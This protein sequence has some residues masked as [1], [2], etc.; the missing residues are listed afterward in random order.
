M[1]HTPHPKRFQRKRTKGW[2]M[3]PGGVCCTRPGSRGN[4]FTVAQLRDL[5]YRMSDED[6]RQYCV[7]CFRQW[8]VRPRWDQHWMG[9]E[10][11]AARE[12][13]L[14]QLPELRGKP[15]GCFCGLDQPCH[16][17]VICE[18]ANPVEQSDA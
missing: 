15:L 9:P 17:D 18:L 14:A 12:K 5:G 11:E 6:A 1:T 4:P 8:L 3:P 2:R 10:S 7:D 13:L 16:V